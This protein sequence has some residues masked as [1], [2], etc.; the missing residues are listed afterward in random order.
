MRVFRCQIGARTRRQYTLTQLR[1]GSKLPSLR[2]PLPEGRGDYEIIPRKV[3]IRSASC[4]GLSLR[5][6]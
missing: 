2:N 4:A 6:R 5:M 3:A 1:L